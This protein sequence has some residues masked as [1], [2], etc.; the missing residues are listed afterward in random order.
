MIFQ[1]KILHG[2]E[3]VGQLVEFHD[4][5]TLLMGVFEFVEFFA[6]LGDF[7]EDA[8]VYVSNMV[9]GHEQIMTQ[10][11]A[12]L[13][14]LNHSSSTTICGGELTTVLPVP[15]VTVITSTSVLPRS[16]ISGV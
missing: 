9:S 11:R 15:V 1:E 6:D 14:I 3:H 13:Q 2:S 4:A 7:S 8:L 5:D 12:N 16:P 10:A